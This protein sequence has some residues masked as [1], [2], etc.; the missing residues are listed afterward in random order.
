MATSFFSGITEGLTSWF[1][2]IKDGFESAINLFFTRAAEGG[3]ING[4]TDIGT[5]LTWAIGVG[6]FGFA[7]SFV[8]RLCRVR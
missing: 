8:L 5:L 2:V 3:A 1:G 6:V 4:L 7:L